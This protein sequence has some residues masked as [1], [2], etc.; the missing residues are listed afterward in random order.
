MGGGFSKQSQHKL[1][2]LAAAEHQRLE[3]KPP[4]RDDIDD[5]SDDEDPEM[6]T[7]RLRRIEK[8]RLKKR[9][10]KEMKKLSEL[11]MKTMEE[12]DQACEELKD[13]IRSRIK[14]RQLTTQHLSTLFGKD[15]YGKCRYKLPNRSHDY[16]H[17]EIKDI[18]LSRTNDFRAPCPV[19]VSV[20][21]DWQN[22]V[23]SSRGTAT[24]KFEVH[25]LHGLWKIKDT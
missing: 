25:R 9:Q 14:M 22:P 5:S 10:E 24:E 1:A 18:S 19:N 20:T 23:Q 4:S 3:F 15:L 12:E 2:K 21:Y 8:V 11:R 6:R 13:M 16:D 7:A 17:I